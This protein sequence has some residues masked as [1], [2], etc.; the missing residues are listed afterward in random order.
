MSGTRF[1][2][3]TSCKFSSV[4][5]Q[6]TDV[7]ENKLHSQNAV[8]SL[9]PIHRNPNTRKDSVH[10]HFPQAVTVTLRTKRFM[11]CFLQLTF[12]TVS[13]NLSCPLC[14][15]PPQK[16]VWVAQNCQDSTALVQRQNHKKFYFRGLLSIIKA[17]KYVPSTNTMQ[18]ADFDI[19]SKCL[20]M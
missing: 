5:K 11:Q 17:L 10:K 19:Q 12:K 1:C 14:I 7:A 2:S 3:D 13:F 16:N 8:C 6:K 4:W 9:T 20:N 15:Y 18:A